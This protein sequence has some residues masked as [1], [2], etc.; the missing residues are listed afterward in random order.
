M[1]AIFGEMDKPA[2]G[3]MFFIILALIGLVGIALVCVR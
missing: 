3:R 1:E 2:L